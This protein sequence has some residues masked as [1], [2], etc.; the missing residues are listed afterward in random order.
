MCDL[1]VQKC[2][3][4]NEVVFR[5]RK[6]KTCTLLI[7]SVS[8]DPLVVCVLDCSFTGKMFNYA[9]AGIA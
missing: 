9:V 3:R 1:R 6:T 8:T 5:L 2:I 4:S 7:V